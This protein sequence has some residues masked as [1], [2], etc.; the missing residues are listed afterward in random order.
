MTRTQ[1]GFQSMIQRN[2]RPTSRTTSQRLPLCDLL[3]LLG[4]FKAKAAE[5]QNEG[6]L[7]GMH[8]GRL[9]S[10]HFAYNF[11]LGLI[12]TSVTSVSR[13][14]S[15]RSSVPRAISRAGTSLVVS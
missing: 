15:R 1:L 10:V 11:L 6:Q 4:A 9:R 2:V 8:L 7:G 3:H 13:D 14:N 5:P 12:I